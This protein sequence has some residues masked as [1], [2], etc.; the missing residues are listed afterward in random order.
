MLTSDTTSKMKIYID[1]K[2][3]KIDLS[4]RTARP[5]VL[6]AIQGYGGAK[7]NPKPGF[8]GILDISSYTNGKHNI[9]YCLEQADGTKIQQETYQVTFDN[10]VK[11]NV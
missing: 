11:R 3:T 1:G 2:D 6:S 10:Q 4:K 5:D 7:I 9:T 8:E